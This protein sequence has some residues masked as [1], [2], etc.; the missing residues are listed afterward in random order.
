MGSSLESWK[1]NNAHWLFTWSEKKTTTPGV[2]EVSWTLSST[3][4][5][6]SPRWY[7]TRGEFECT[8]TDEKGVSRTITRDLTASGSTKG[9][10]GV[11]DPEGEAYLINYNKGEQDKGTFKCKHDASGAA[12]FSVTFTIDKIFTTF[13]E[14][15]ITAD[16]FDLTKNVP[17]AKLSTPS[18]VTI[19]PLFAPYQVTSIEWDAVSGAAGYIT[20]Y[21]WTFKNETTEGSADD[22]W[23]EYNI[24]SNSDTYNVWTREQ[25]REKQLWVRVRAKSPGGTDYYSDWSA[26]VAGRCNTLPAAPTL[27]GG[28]DFVF[29][30]LGGSVTFTLTPGADLEDP[31]GTKSTV[32][33]SE[34]SNPGAGDRAECE[35][36]IL[37]K[38]FTSDSTLYFWTYDGMEFGEEYAQANVRKNIVPQIS[39]SIEDG[40]Q[41]N[42]FQ[43]N[44]TVQAEVIS[45]SIGEK[46]YLYTFG[47]K[48]NK[49]DEGWQS[50][51][52]IEKTDQSKYVYEDLRYLLCQNYT[53][54]ARP[55]VQGDDYEFQIWAECYDGTDYSSPA[56]LIENI[57]YTVPT[58]KKMSEIANYN[59]IYFSDTLSLSLEGAKSEDNYANL[60]VDSISYYKPTGI[61]GLQVEN[62]NTLA[63]PSGARVD[64][65]VINGEPKAVS[66]DLDPKPFQ[67]KVSYVKINSFENDHL[68]KASFDKT[69]F[70][71]ASAT[72]SLNVTLTAFADPDEYGF[73]E[74]QQPDLWIETRQGDRKLNTI[75]GNDGYYV[76]SLHNKDLWEVLGEDWF[77]ND[78]VSVVFFSNNVFGEKRQY[79]HVFQRSEWETPLV[80]S[81]FFASSEEHSLSTWEFLVEGQEIEYKAAVQTRER[82]NV[83]MSAIFYDRA[84]GVK[85][86]SIN[87]ELSLAAVEVKNNAWNCV[88][89]EYTSESTFTIPAALN[90]QELQLKLIVNNTE[91]Q[92]EANSQVVRVPVPAWK[93]PEGGFSSLTIEDKDLKYSYENANIS[94]G[95]DDK[96]SPI[97]TLIGVQARD[98]E[99]YLFSNE[100]EPG[101]I[102]NF[103]F[104]GAEFLYLSPIFETTVT[105]TYLEDGRPTKG[106]NPFSKT[107]T[108]FTYTIIY[109]TVPT[110]AY[111]KNT[112][113]INTL[114][115]E[116]WSDGQNG[117]AVLVV[118]Q[119]SADKRKIALRGSDRQIIID[120]SSGSAEGL[121]VDCGSW[122]EGTISYVRR[123][124]PEFIMSEDGGQGELIDGIAALYR[125]YSDETKPSSGASTEK[126]PLRYYDQ[127]GGQ[128]VVYED[129]EG[130]KDYADCYTYSETIVFEEQTLEKW[131]GLE[132]QAGNYIL[133]EPITILT[134]P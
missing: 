35:N 30:S 55:L 63:M 32:Y 65:V 54:P 90:D 126:R 87:Q 127:S 82:P 111:R 71:P 10:F 112:V 131:N 59:N 28:P 53:G 56:Q 42:F 103:N 117:Q 105:P 110:V 38:D 85:S 81:E 52:L 100:D 125:Y 45:D 8:Y 128:L 72:G 96:Y 58:I 66:G 123:I 133:I 101:T 113:G 22:D 97:T 21:Q 116:N 11:W 2:T 39:L 27:S 79:S 62:I 114:S 120:L 89:Y 98:G 74:Q 76:Y 51:T 121:V 67:I 13:D 20:S 34:T 7:S 86:S 134:Y 93:A 48:F 70:N 9:D 64:Q 5:S 78:Q 15:K 46:E 115:P 60:T 106:E 19:T 95:I 17:Y 36:G 25:I 37:T 61:E 99:A 47:Y 4:R 132:E 23:S 18:N 43:G 92:L 107:T 109:N 91:Y 3:G 88:L 94:K 12:S 73:T 83:T 68:K 130:E 102:K 49:N 14:S 44:V 129:Y 16:T 118:S 26:P 33:W 57:K 108:L 1:Y 29:P 104:N 40:S 124:S 24:K 41:E 77:N 119:V 6:T 84:T 69:N 122:G 80:L 50:Y 31:E 75:E